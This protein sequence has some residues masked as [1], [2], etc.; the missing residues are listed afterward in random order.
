MSFGSA[1]NTDNI[2]SYSRCVDSYSRSPQ[3]AVLLVTTCAT[4][5]P[6]PFIIDPTATRLQPQPHLPT[7]PSQHLMPAA[8]IRHRLC[9][10][11]LAPPTRVGM[12]LQV[13]NSGLH[14]LGCRQLPI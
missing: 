13:G 14:I 6:P 5:P 2:D 4:P 3:E 8:T 9:F 11:F 12:P 7:P 1:P 10:L